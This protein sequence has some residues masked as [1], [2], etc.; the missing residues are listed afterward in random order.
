MKEKTPV[1]NVKLANKT[2]ENK[3]WFSGIELN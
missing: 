3:Q 2:I 1:F